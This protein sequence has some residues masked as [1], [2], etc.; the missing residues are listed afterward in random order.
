MTHNFPLDDLGT[1][2]AAVIYPNDSA[3]VVFT[4]GI[5]PLLNQAFDLRPHSLPL[6]FRHWHSLAKSYISQRLEVCHRIYSCAVTVAHKNSTVAITFYPIRSSSPMLAIEAQQYRI[7]CESALTTN[8][9]F[10]D[11]MSIEETHMA[12]TVTATANTVRR[13]DPSID[14]LGD[15]SNLNN[16]LPDSGA[17]HST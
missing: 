3:R 15:P 11:E 4:Q 14:I 13:P 12:L 7:F 5:I 6:C 10:D 17:I 16:Y 9:V 1:R 8:I 2:F